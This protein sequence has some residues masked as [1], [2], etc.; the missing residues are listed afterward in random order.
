M[1]VILVPVLG[2]V[3]GVVLGAVA[4]A[5]PQSSRLLDTFTTPAAVK[6]GTDQNDGSETEVKPTAPEAEEEG[7]CSGSCRR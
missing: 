4:L 7:C 1:R 6:D 5:L 2:I 3:L